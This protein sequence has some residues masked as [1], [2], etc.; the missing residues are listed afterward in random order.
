MVKMNLEQWSG[1]LLVLKGADKQVGLYG[2]ELPVVTAFWARRA[3]RLISAETEDYQKQ[4]NDLVLKYG[5]QTGDSFGIA[6]T[7]PKFNTFMAEWTPL[8]TVEL[9]IPIDPIKREDLGTKLDI[10]PVEIDMLG[11]LIEDET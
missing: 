6:P 1:V 3:I 8:A 9:E 11:G 5:E 10:K 4:K 7:S 2:K